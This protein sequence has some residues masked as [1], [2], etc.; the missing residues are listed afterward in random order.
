MLPAGIALT[1]GEASGLLD[2]WASSP[3]EVY[4]RLRV[5][6]QRPSEST[7]IR[8]MLPLTTFPSPFH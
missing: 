4:A 8:R 3:K 7:A 5:F 2:A 6:R 1:A